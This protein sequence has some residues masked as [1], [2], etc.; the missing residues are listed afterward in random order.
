LQDLRCLTM[1]ANNHPIAS[2]SMRTQTHTNQRYAH[3]LCF[4]HYFTSFACSALGTNESKRAQGNIVSS[5]EAR[6]EAESLCFKTPGGYAKNRLI[7]KRA[8][9]MA[10]QSSPRDIKARPIIRLFYRDFRA[11]TKTG[12]VCAFYVSCPGCSACASQSLDGSTMNTTA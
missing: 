9:M 1:D 6:C 2:S 11:T 10:L 12:T 5:A 4:L 7:F 3:F 8:G